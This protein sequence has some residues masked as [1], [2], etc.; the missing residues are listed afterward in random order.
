MET[1]I[2]ESLGIN[3]PATSTHE[4]TENTSAEKALTIIANIVLIV[5]VIGTL[6]MAFTITY[7]TIE[8][9]YNWQDETMVNPM[10]IVLTI[11]TLMSS[12]TVWGLLKVICNIST[13]LKE[14][15]LKTK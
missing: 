3:N 2:N 9:K 12:V 1:N 11:A 4:E 13:S 6:I 10:G 15:N 14:I 8:G 7:T 5:G